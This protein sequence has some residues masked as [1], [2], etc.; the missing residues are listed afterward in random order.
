MLYVVWREDTREH[1][2]LI[3]WSQLNHLRSQ[4]DRL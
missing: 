2:K 4:N 3:I 1:T